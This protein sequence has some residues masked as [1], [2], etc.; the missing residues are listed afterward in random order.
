MKRYETFEKEYPNLDLIQCNIAIYFIFTYFCGAVYDNYVYSAAR[1]AIFSSRVIKFLAF[2][3]WYESG[4]AE[5]DII[6]YK[7]CRE[8]EHSNDNLNLIK[9]ELDLQ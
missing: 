4:E 5:V 2:A 8:L 9:Q 3:K 7:F 1:L 6:I